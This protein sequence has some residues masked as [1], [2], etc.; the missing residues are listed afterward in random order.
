MTQGLMYSGW[1]SSGRNCLFNS[2]F[3]KFVTKG[4]EKKNPIISSYHLVASNRK[5]N[6]QKGKHWLSY[7]EIPALGL[8]S[9][10]GGFMG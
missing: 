1:A 5:L 10:K 8:A 4:R 9:G 2:D 6:H 3:R 7:L